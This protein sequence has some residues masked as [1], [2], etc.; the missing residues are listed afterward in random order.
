MRIFDNRVQKIKYKVLRELAR[1]TW[2]G[3]DAFT[4]FNEIASQV[5]KKGEPPMRCCIY[6]DR[7]IIADRMRI[8]LGNCL[9]GKSTIQ[10][11][12]IA[13][14]ECPT[15]GHSV[16]DLCRG[17]IAKSCKEHCPADAIFIDEKKKA[18]IDKE[19]CI[20]C[21]KCAESCQYHAITNLRRPCEHACPA[22]AITAD[23]DGAAHIIKEKCIVCGECMWKCPFGALQDRSSI[24][25]I[26]NELKNAGSSRIFAIIAPAIVT[27]FHDSSL[28]QV[29]TALKNLGF[30][31]VVE[32]AAGADIAAK[33][34][35]K[36][37]A[38]K[39]FLTSS[40]C[41]AFVEYIRTNF[42]E[43][44]DNV[45]SVPSP[46]TITA[47]E[48][49]K[50]YPDS[51]I[52]FIGPCI[53]K[54]FERNRDDVKDYVYYVMTFEELQAMFDARDI[55]LSLLEETSL[56]DASPFG[57]GFSMSGGVTNAVQQAIV[58]LGLDVEFKPVVCNGIRE[59]KTALTKAKFGRLDGNF[60]E[61]MAC[62]G[63]CIAGNGTLINKG[64]AAKMVGEYCSSAEKKTIL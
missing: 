33:E 42:P 63:G 61:G 17:C 21:G 3:E 35:A 38:E 12:T 24:V 20:E 47:K 62:R 29:V 40:C 7:A 27:Q 41:P 39:G 53:S 58:E 2:M 19:K 6:K 18:H 31:D 8:G 56:Q 16:T 36:E 55:N 45:S 34:D 26:V 51:R 59:C 23:E 9:E 50:D 30:T 14:D 32:V 11:V 37:L 43:R 48:I 5:V 15:S 46:M 1:H 49:K 22:D 44:S 64:A 13:C 10:V 25:D 57:R 28:G 4:A 60:I 52:I 54:K